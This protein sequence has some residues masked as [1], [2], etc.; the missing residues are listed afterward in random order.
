MENLAGSLE[1]ENEHEH[2][3]DLVAAGK[4][5]NR[6]HVHHSRDCKNHFHVGHFSDKSAFDGTKEWNY[7]KSV[8]HVYNQGKCASDWVCHNF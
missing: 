5:I 4:H 2:F 1:L 7:C 8:N 3:A 6:K